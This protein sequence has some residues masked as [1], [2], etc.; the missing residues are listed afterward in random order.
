MAVP[1][2]AIEWWTKFADGVKSQNPFGR[3]LTSSALG[4]WNFGTLADRTKLQAYHH[5]AHA[6]DY[7]VGSAY[8]LALLI[9]VYLLVCRRWS[10]ASAGAPAAR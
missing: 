1:A 3:Y 9:V 6:P 10:W 7:Q 4:S 8:V 2:A 5:F